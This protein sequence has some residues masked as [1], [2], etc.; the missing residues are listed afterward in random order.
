MYK[1]KP[2]EEKKEDDDLKLDKF[3]EDDDDEPEQ[4]KLN[5]EIDMKKAPARRGAAKGFSVAAANDQPFGDTAQSATS[6]LTIPHRPRGN[7]VKTKK[8]TIDIP[9]LNPNTG[10]NEAP[11]I[12]PNKP[13][14]QSQQDFS[15]NYRSEELSV[16]NLN[17]PPNPFSSS[18]SNMDLTQDQNANNA[19][20]SDSHTSNVAD[21]Y[22][23][24]IFMDFRT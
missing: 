14:T 11:V 23:S 16:P 10:S 3:F 13:I 18:N 22:T 12:T 21:Q 20:E 7:T 15:A 4:K 17:Q 9:G 2:V 1:E 19:N 6:S 8:F 24:N 5:F